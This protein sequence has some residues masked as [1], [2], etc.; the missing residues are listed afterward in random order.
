[1]KSKFKGKKLKLEKNIYFKNKNLKK[2]KNSFKFCTNQCQQIFNLASE[3]IKSIKYFN[4][5][6]KT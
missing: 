2:N 3:I 6:Y 4:K 1:M 5:F